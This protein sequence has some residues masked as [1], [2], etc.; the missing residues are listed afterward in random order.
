MV[1]SVVMRYVVFFC[2]FVSLVSLIYY[3]SYLAAG[4]SVVGAVVGSV[5]CS[6]VVVVVIAAL[7]WHYYWRHHKASL[8]ESG[9]GGIGTRGSRDS[10]VHSNKLQDQSGTLEEKSNNQNEENL[11]RFRNPLHAKDNVGFSVIGAT[12]TISTVPSSSTISPSTSKEVSEVVEIDLVEK[13]GDIHSNIYKAQSPEMCKNTTPSDS[14]SK[15]FQKDFS[16]KS[17]VRRT[18]VV[19]KEVIV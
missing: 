11:R 1:V 5:V 3:F 15:D 18:P 9:R 8:E 10:V 12:A 4:T 2:L 7:L 17:S 14:S 19:D 13:S 6:I 16:L